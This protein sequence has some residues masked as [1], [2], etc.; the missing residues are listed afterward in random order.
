MCLYLE[1]LRATREARRKEAAPDSA[2]DDASYALKA[3]PTGSCKE[4]AEETLGLSCMPSQE[5]S[6]VEGPQFLGNVL[7]VRRASRRQKTEEADRETSNRCRL[8]RRRQKLSL[9][10]FQC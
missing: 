8:I 7:V 1:D 2:P 9:F 10:P 6:L 3:L 4:E 5:L